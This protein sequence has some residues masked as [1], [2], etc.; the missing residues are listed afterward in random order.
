MQVCMQE[1]LVFRPCA[2]WIGQ[3]LMVWFRSP[4]RGKGLWNGRLTLCIGISSGGTDTHLL[5]M[6]LY[7]TIPSSLSPWVFWKIETRACGRSE[8]SSVSW[9]HG[10][11]MQYDQLVDLSPKVTNPG[12]FSFLISEEWTGSWNRSASAPRYKLVTDRELHRCFGKLWL[13]PAVLFDIEQ[14]RSTLHQVFV[15][16]NRCSS[17]CCQS[18]RLDKWIWCNMC[19]IICICIYNMIYDIV[20]YITKASR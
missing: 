20:S 14:P 17:I 5:P 1:L 12:P 7:I 3:T 13:N 11:W 19:Y 18:C 15:D 8:F 4:N 9:T 10:K 6:I 16:G 2:L